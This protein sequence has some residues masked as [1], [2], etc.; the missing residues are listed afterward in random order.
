MATRLRHL[1]SFHERHLIFRRAGQVLGDAR[2]DS[3][4][5]APG[6]RRLA[7]LLTTAPS[8]IEDEA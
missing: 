8:G 6:T 2:Q 1:I 7:I 4:Q 5:E 3:R